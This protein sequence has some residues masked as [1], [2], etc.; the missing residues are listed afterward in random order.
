M[1]SLG[2]AR[3]DRDQPLQKPGLGPDVIASD[4]HAGFIE[5]QLGIARFANCDGFAI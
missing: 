3:K 2:N 5:G 1:G 4:I